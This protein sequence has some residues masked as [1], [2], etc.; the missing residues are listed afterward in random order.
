VTIGGLSEIGWRIAA[1]NL[2]TVIVQ[3]GGYLLDTLGES[4]VAFLQAFA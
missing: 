4:S 2:P 3:E 1:L